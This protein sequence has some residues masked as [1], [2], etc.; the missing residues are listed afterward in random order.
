VCSPKAEF[1]VDGVTYTAAIS[2]SS[3]SCPSVG[4][5]VTVIYDP[6]N[7][8]STGRIAKP[9]WLKIFT[10]GFPAIGVLLILRGVWMLIRRFTS[11]AVA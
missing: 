2:I 4:S 7:P 9:G 1:T 8:A 3:S 5:K 6:A 10:L 11:R